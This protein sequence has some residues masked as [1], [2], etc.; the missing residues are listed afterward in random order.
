MGKRSARAVLRSATGAL[1][2]VTGLALLCGCGL[3]DHRETA[4]GSGGTGSAQPSVA[5][6]APVP[7]GKP[8]GPDAHVPDPGVVDEDDATAVSEAWAETTYGYDTA[9]D[10]SPQDAVLRG[11]RWCTERKAA[12]ERQYR[13]ASGPGSEWIT[14]ARH[15]AWTTVDVSSELED[16]APPDGEQIAYRSLVV[17][18]TAHGRDGWEGTGPRL[19]AYVK[20]V[21]AGVGDPWRVDDVTVVEAAR[22]PEPSTSASVGSPSDDSRQ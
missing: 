2:V 4:S 7:S 16:D 20:L 15:R 21:R 10:N 22:P 1:A 13:P 3:S 17:S 12:A 9:Y 6:K 19:N 14:W 18:G 5:P 8:L 11:V